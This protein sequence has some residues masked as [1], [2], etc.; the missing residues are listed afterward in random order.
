[1]F[2]LCRELCEEDLAGARKELLQWVSEHLE[3]AKFCLTL[4]EFEVEAKAGETAA[5]WVTRFVISY[6]EEVRRRLSAALIVFR[7]TS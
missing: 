2:S 6:V 7:D 1:M 5:D 3:C 4:C